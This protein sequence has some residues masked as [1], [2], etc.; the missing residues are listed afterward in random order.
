MLLEHFRLPPLSLFHKTSSGTIDTVNCAQTLRNE[1]KISSDVCLMFYK[2]YLQKYEEYFAGHLVGC[3]SEGELYKGLVCF[4]IIGLKNSIPYVI[5]SSPETK[6]NAD[7]LKEELIDCLGIFSKFG[8]IVTAMVCD[9]RPSNVSSFKNLLQHFKQDPDEL[10]IWYELRKIYLFYDAVHLVKNIRNNLLN[11][12]RFIF[13]LFKFDGF[14]D[15]IN[16]PGG[17]IK[18]K[19]FHDVY[20][21][22]ALLEANLRKAPKLTMKVLHSENCKQNVPTALAIFHETA[23]ATIQSYFPDGKSTVEFLKLFSK[24]WAI[25]NSKT[26]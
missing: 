24:W 11:Y 2:M 9:S 10:F 18:S 5:Q 25:S 15:P 14:K 4:M 13:P 12:K 23:A 22:D 20:E 17:E 26:A 16:F 7:W 6:I 8:F 19:F 1:D 21:K 3:N